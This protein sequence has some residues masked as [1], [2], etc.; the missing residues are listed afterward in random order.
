VAAGVVGSVDEAFRD[1]LRTGGKYY[2]PKDDTP[3]ATAVEMVRAAGGVP[4]FAHPFARRRGP[5]VEGSAIVELVDRGLGGVEVDHPDHADGDRQA[6]RELAREHG[7]LT[8]GSSD[9]HGTNKT[10]P[11]AAETT[12]PEVLEAIVAQASGAAPVSGRS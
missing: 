8:T 12:A 10:T 7:L 5:V 4:V 2:V 9:Y 6:L 3:I 11:I 1:L